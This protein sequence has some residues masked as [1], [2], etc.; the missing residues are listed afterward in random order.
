MGG[1]FRN[2]QI[3]PLTD[4]FGFRVPEDALA[5]WIECLDDAVLV[6]RDDDVLDVIENDLQMLGALLAGFVRHGARFIGHEPHRLNDAAPFLINGFVM[7]ADDAQQNCKVRGSGVRIPQAQLFQLRPKLV[8][9]L[10]TVLRAER[11]VGAN[12]SSRCAFGA[13]DDRLFS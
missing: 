13:R 4:H 1:D 8:V 12:D 11:V 3:D 10:G 6:H 7:S 9:Q 2:Q 5:C